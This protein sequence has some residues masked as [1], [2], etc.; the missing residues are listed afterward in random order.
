MNLQ[1]SYTSNNIQFSADNDEYTFNKGTCEISVYNS[2]MYINSNLSDNDYDIIKFGNGISKDDVEFSKLNGNLMISIKGSN[3]KITINNWLSSEKCK[4]ELFEFVDGS[5]ITKDELAK[6][7]SLIQIANNNNYLQFTAENDLYVFNRGSGTVIID[8]IFGTQGSDIVKFGNNILKDNVEFIKIKNSLVAKIKNTTDAVIIKDW[9]NS[10][11]AKI[12]KF[13]FAD[14]TIITKNNIDGK[15]EN[16]LIQGTNNNDLLSGTT[17]NDTL[18]GGTGNDALI[19]GAGNDTYQFSSGDGIDEII[20]SS[21]TDTLKF[22]SSV[23]SSDLYYLQNGN[24]LLIK[25]KTNSDKIIIDNWYSSSDNR[26]ES[27]LFSDETSV[28]ID[29]TSLPISE[30]I[31]E[32]NTLTLNVLDEYNGQLAIDS[33]IQST[34][35]V[36]TINENNE[37]VYTPNVNYNGSDSF[38]YVLGD[39]NGGTVTKT[40]D[41]TVN[42][43]NDT[44][45]A[46]LTSAILDEDGF[47]VL[48]V[49]AIASDVDGDTLTIDSFTQGTHGMI[50]KNAENKLVYTPNSNYNGTDT[51]TYKLSDG[52]GGTVTKTVDLTINSVNDTPTATLTSAILE[53]DSSV[54]LDILLNSSDVDGDTLVIDSF[55]QG[56]NGAVT[57]NENNELIYTPNTHFSGSDSFTYTLSDGN[58]IVTQAINLTVN[59]LPVNFSGGSTNDI[60]TGNYKDNILDGG[61]GADTM[62]GGAGNDTY[63][64][65]NAGDVI[66]ENTG[67]GIDTVY[68]S[69]AYTLGDN[70]E[71]LTYTGSQDFS[72]IVGNELNNVIIGNSGF[73][74]MDGGIG[75][76][77]MIGGLGN[78][79]YFVDNVGD[80]I[81]E[82]LNEGYEIVN[83]SVSYTLSS[84]LERLELIEGSTAIEASGNDLSNTS[85]ET[86]LITF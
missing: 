35:G 47:V 18:T 81:V 22:D 5:T 36:V 8:N 59:P 68:S 15:P 6:I 24:N 38:A 40:V 57:V 76:D 53:E 26:V 62:A 25:N 17:G 23:L 56:A 71:N 32:D 45:T 46:T 11:N 12:D 37:L 82:N 85:E 10:E 9:D 55:T 7:P 70:V 52:N 86:R 13:E 20:D 84:N 58:D 61:I 64:V 49:L 69:I 41:L 78:D 50:V 43:V 34:N 65:D 16:I 31:D 14:G 1:S 80:V 3:D 54:I 75:A 30:T 77:T 66:T 2:Y 27:I 63:Y 51:F 4:V 74:I 79:G 29:P 28:D 21:G 42:S 72:R 83:S 19:G 73:N 67:E 39:G 44:P 33:I 60:L 48:D